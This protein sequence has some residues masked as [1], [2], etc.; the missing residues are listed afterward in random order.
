MQLDLDHPALSEREC[1]LLERWTAYLDE[2]GVQAPQIEDFVSFGS[3]S[4]LENLR[5]ALNKVTPGAIGPLRIALKQLRSAKYRRDH[6]VPETRENRKP[7]VPASISIAEAQLPRPWQRALRDMR[8]LRETTNE[9]MLALDDR[10]PPSAK[11]IQSLSS[12]LRVFAKTCLDHDLLIEITRE[13]LDIWR[14]VRHE[15]GNKQRS[16]ASRLKELL[17]FSIWCELD[18]EIIDRISELRQRYNRAGQG[19]RKRKEIWMLIHDVGLSDVWSRAEDLLELALGAPMGTARRTRLVLDACCLAM[20]VACPL[21]CG[22]LHRIRFGDNLRRNA[23]SWSL[24]I[25]TQKGDIDYH[26]PEL[27]P[28][29]TPFLD[30]VLMLDLR[31]CSVEDAMELKSGTDLFSRDGGKTGVYVSW[32]TRCWLRHYGIG[33]HI[34]RT[35]WH[36][37]MFESEDDDQWIALAL[38]GQKGIRTAMHYVVAGRHRRATRRG[39]DKIRAL[40][41]SATAGTAQG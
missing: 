33:E 1:R 31:D 7:R 6:P 12:T 41:T 22:D 32:P 27:W 23:T 24:K 26:R 10:N 11:V 40:R 4:K 21:R 18:E 3:A 35:L 19:E 39:R 29:L 5:T 17:L 16:I 37:M 13:T 30:A 25:R 36:T 14:R 38:C 20:S 2:R 15:A 34:V 8:R 9:G 28:E